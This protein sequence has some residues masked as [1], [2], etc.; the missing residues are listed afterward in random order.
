MIKEDKSMKEIHKIME[1]LHDKRAKMSTEEIIT[2]I[3]EGAE[4]IKKEYN[5]KLK[6]IIRVKLHGCLIIH[7]LNWNAYR[8]RFQ[9]YKTK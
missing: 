8:D 4:K 5:T 9:N 3:K 6:M 1:D 2:E 7:L